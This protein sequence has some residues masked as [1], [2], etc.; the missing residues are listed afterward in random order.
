[1]KPNGEKINMSDVAPQ[2]YTFAMF[3]AVDEAARRQQKGQDLPGNI[4]Q[5]VGDMLQ[6]VLNG[7]MYTPMRDAVRTYEDMTRDPATGSVTPGLDKGETTKRNPAMKLLSKQG[8]TSIVPRLSGQI[9]KKYDR[10]IKAPR[11]FLEDIKADIPGLSKSVPNKKDIFG[12]DM[13]YPESPS[14]VERTLGKGTKGRND[15]VIDMMVDLNWFPADVPN[16]LDGVK[17]TTEAVNRIKA[18]AGPLAY[19]TMSHL[20]N[21]KS[22]RKLPQQEQVKMLEDMLSAP[23][24]MFSDVERVKQFKGMRSMPDEDKK[25]IN[26]YKNKGRTTMFPFP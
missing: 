26:Y 20:A 15:P 5:G 24:A 10:G 21:S 22:F 6:S 17:L 1:M 13:T 2:G 3:A 18:G 19:K 4:K 14:V 8:A 7:T 9:R 23:R 11:N 16:T 12:R 25:S